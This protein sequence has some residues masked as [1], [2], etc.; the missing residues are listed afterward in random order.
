MYDP[1]EAEISLNILK[2]LS[3]ECKKRNIPIAI[4]GG[5]A[6][7][8]YVNEIYFMAF[9]KSYMGSRD[10][11]VYFD[12]NKEKEL[13][14]LIKT[15]GFTPDGMYFRWE[16]RYN[17]ETKK[18]MQPQEAKNE[19]VFNLIHIFL[20][21]F[22][23]KETKILKS[24]CLEEA[25]KNKKYNIINGFSVVDIDTL[26]N[27]K[28]IALFE[29]DKSDKENKD[30]CDLYALLNYSQKKIKSTELLG[31]AIEKIINRFDLLYVIAQH[32]LLDAGKQNIVQYSL[33][34][35]LKELQ[36]Q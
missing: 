8:F 2:E 11:D 32:V 28:C 18:F 1:V 35:K 19:H 3:S 17:R 34:S 31:K 6:T 10:I 12:H 14:Q 25:F 4:I 29:R 16:K 26:T 36:Q 7:S 23:D 20:D 22:C 33:N 30:A 13:L 9:G 5:W 21:I 15:M 24:W 27:L